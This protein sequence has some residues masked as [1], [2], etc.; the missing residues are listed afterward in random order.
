[1]NAFERSADAAKALNINSAVDR[2]AEWFP[3]KRNIKIMANME[4]AETG[5]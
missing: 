2:V 5:L 1:M 4:R 3:Q